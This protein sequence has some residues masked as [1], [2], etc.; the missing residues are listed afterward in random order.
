MQGSAF[1]IQGG[2]VDLI[3]ASIVSLCVVNCIATKFQIEPHTNLLKGSISNFMA[4][5]FTTH[6][7][8]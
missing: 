3:P 2:S 5:Q 4:I 6:N 8:L 7:D 1:M